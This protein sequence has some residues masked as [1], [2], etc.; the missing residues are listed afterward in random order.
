MGDPKPPMPL[1][2]PIAFPAAA[3]ADD[4]RNLRVLFQSVNES[5]DSRKSRD[6]SDC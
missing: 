4:P 3:I 5:D 1:L 6:G 2:P